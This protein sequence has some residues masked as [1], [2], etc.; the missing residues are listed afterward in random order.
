MVISQSKSKKSPSGSR[1]VPLRKKRQCETGREPTLTKLGD[2]KRKV[3]KVLGGNN[4]YVLLQTDIANVMDKKTKK[5][6]KAKILSVKANPANSNYIRRNIITKG[7]T[8]STDKG[9]VVVTS[10]PAQDGTINGYII[11]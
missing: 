6:V 5:S 2:V 1:Y 8:I 3:L 4:K 9:D 10:R 11:N 7:C